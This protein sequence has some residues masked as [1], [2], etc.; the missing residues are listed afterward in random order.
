MTDLVAENK[1][2]KQSD[3]DEEGDSSVSREEDVERV[4]FVD[5]A[6]EADGGE[7]DD[8][9]DSFEAGFDAGDA[10]A[11]GTS[12]KTGGTKTTKANKHKAGPNSKKVITGASTS[13]SS[14]ATED[15]EIQ[16]LSGNGAAAASSSSSSGRFADLQNRNAFRFG[17]ENSVAISSNDISIISAEGQSAASSPTTR[18]LAE[19]LLNMQLAAGSGGTASSTNVSAMQPP[20][21]LMAAD[22]T[23][24]NV[25]MK[26]ATAARN[27][28]SSAGR[29]SIRSSRGG[30]GNAFSSNKS[31]QL[32][33]GMTEEMIHT[34]EVLWPILIAS[35][36]FQDEKLVATLDITCKT[37]YQFNCEFLV[38]K[39]LGLERYFGLE[40]SGKD[41]LVDGEQF[42]DDESSCESSMDSDDEMSVEDVAA[43]LEDVGGATA[44]GRHQQQ[45]CSSSEQKAAKKNANPLDDDFNEKLGDSVV[46]EDLNVVQDNKQWRSRYFRF[47]KRMLQFMSGR[48]D[49]SAA[50]AYDAF[51]WK[52]GY[53]TNMIVDVFDQ[54]EVAY[55]KATLQK[56]TVNLLN[57]YLEIEV[58]ENADNL[59]LAIVDFDKGGKS[60]V[61]FS[62]DT[63]AVIKETKVQEMPRKVVG[64]YV[65]PLTRKKEKFR[66]RMGMLIKEGHLAFYRKYETPDVQ[67]EW[68]C[69]GYV[70]SF[71]WAEDGNRLTPCIAFRD[72]GKYV[73]R[74]IC[75]GDQRI[76][77]CRAPFQPAEPAHEA[78]YLKAEHKAEWKELNWNDPDAASDADESDVGEGE[79]ENM[80]LDVAEADDDDEP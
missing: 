22:K 2:R 10:S 31:A 51:A 69:T 48:G 7:S 41:P 58:T 28:R 75:F 35:G 33:A 14:S 59:S 68:E 37:F 16:V 56:G 67:S 29:L 60:S 55:T 25:F 20:N 64:S 53:N 47:K 61:T 63:G 79:G 52:D 71:D 6:A 17:D 44:S 19:G 23:T 4:M 8:E 80:Q 73:A 45:S 57:L 36:Y 13:A 66:G 1:R 77:N 65:Q 26:S 74:I 34:W 30:N 24:K 3:G 70:V 76:E 39:R 40:L 27:S 49:S 18:F 72:K 42:A 5:E 78:K 46:F 43:D 12:G 11:A 62:P 50:D 38:W 9:V 21:V 15:P 54:D 32:G